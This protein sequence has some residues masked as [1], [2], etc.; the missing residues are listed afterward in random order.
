M[1]IN[2]G[3]VSTAIAIY[4]NTPS[5]TFTYKLF[6]QRPREEAME[7]AIQIGCKN[8]HATQRIMYY[9]AAHG[10][11][12]LRM[13]SAL[14]PLA[15]HPDVMINVSAEYTKELRKMGEFAYHNHIRL[16]MHPGQFTLLNGSDK[17]VASAIQDL[18]YHAAILDGMGLDM[19]SNINIHVGGVYGDKV[20]ALAKLYDNFPSVP[21][22]V[23]KRITFENDDKTYTTEE[24]L[25]VCERLGVPMVLDLHHDYCNPSSQTPLELLPR[26]LNTWGMISPK[27][28]VSSPKNEHNVRSHADYIAPELLLHFLK[29]CKEANLEQINVMIEAKSK[30]LA[31]FCLAENLAKVRGIKRVDGGILEW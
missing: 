21:D 5:S 19:S 23:R 3:F 27:I 13:S 1:L 11:Q 31:L 24:T 9:C 10:I 25:E 20:A 12:M 29:G 30:D 28:H 14:I 2:L 4:N 7:R 6:S 15:T 8:L 17:V 18:E 26:I 16:S 22:Y